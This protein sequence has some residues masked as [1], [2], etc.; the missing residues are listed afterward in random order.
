[1]SQY[2]WNAETDRAVI[3][4]NFAT[5]QSERD[6]IYSRSLHEPCTKLV[7]NVLHTFYNVDY[8]KSQNLYAEGLSHLIKSLHY[9]NPAKGK[10]FTL[11]TLM[12]RQY[13]IG[14]NDAAYKHQIKHVPIVAEPDDEE[15]SEILQAPEEPINWDEFYRGFHLW[16]QTHI[17]AVFPSQKTRGVA[18]KIVE[19]MAD[20]TGNRKSDVFED[21][22]NRTNCDTPKMS[23]VIS[24]MRPYVQELLK[25]YT[26]WGTFTAYG[27]TYTGSLFTVTAHLYSPTLPTIHERHRVSR[28]SKDEIAEMKRFYATGEF[29]VLGLARHLSMPY[30]S[31][32]HILKIESHGHPRGE[33]NLNSKLTADQVNAIRAEYAEGNAT[34]RSIARKYG[35]GHITV[36]RII[37]GEAWTHLPHE[38]MEIRPALRAKKMTADHAR[39][40]FERFWNGEDYNDLATEY[41]VSVSTV[42]YIA[43]RKT[44][45]DVT[46]ELQKEKQLKLIAA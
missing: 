14:Q 43:K 7:E 15:K 41:G 1:M 25:S 32:Y 36:R 10:G 31:L 19:A 16:W 37:K 4:F 24:T 29:T 28:Y 33:E 21:L 8:I 12:V 11:A 3:A 13:F 42:H 20:A 35:V 34:V 39:S 44:W 22:R 23:R 2:Y 46:A 40:I 26:Q 27:L 38:P 6:A 30:T 17:Y 9:Y 18:A 5:S 45:K